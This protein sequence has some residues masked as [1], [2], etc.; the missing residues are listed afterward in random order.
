MLVAL[1]IIS[2]ATGNSVDDAD[3]KE[4]ESAFPIDGSLIT[5]NEDNYRQLLA[6]Q[7]PENI[8]NPK[9]HRP[10][11]LGFVIR[12]GKGNLDFQRE[13]HILTKTVYRNFAVAITDCHFERHI[14]MHFK[15]SHHPALYL[16]VDGKLVRWT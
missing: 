9:K 6:E 16:F 15:P 13:L 1:A 11:V 2:F 5:M 10:L 3:R 14:C 4:N 7:L 12:D 8:K